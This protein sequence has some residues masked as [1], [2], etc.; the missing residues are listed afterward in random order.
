MN[1][2]KAFIPTSKEFPKLAP[3]I[4]GAVMVKGPSRSYWMSDAEMY[5]QK[6]DCQI[7]KNAH[8]KTNTAIKM[9]PNR[10]TSFYLI[11]FP[12]GI[13]L[14]NPIFSGN[15]SFLQMW[16]NGM[17]L[18][19]DHARYPFKKKKKMDVVGICLWW[20]IGIAGRTIIRNGKAEADAV[21]FFH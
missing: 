6:G 8:E 9:D 12:K 18:G 11:V 1:A 5:H 3:F 10:Q 4:G 2:W 14:E 13:I 15:N 16:K 7:T 21:D 19:P 20:R 17:K